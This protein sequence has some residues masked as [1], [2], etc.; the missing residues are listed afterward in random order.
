MQPRCILPL[1]CSM[2]YKLLIAYDGTPFGGWQYQDN[3]PSI[4]AHIEHALSTALRTPISIIG[5]GRT[6]SGVHAL[7]QVAHFSTDAPVSPQRLL[8]SLNALL[9]PDIRIL[10]IETAPEDFHAIY[11]AKAKLYTYHLHLDKQENPFKRH[12]SYRPL[13]PL[14]LTLLKEAAAHFVGTHDFTSFANQ[15]DEGSAAKNPIRTIHRLDVIDE[16]GGV[17]L[18]FQGTGFLYKMVRNITGTLLE[19]STG[20]IPLQSLPEIFAAKDRRKAG[21]TAPAHG[22]FLTEVFY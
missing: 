8:L 17:R 19:I 20:K 9:P 7:G 21:Q 22:L 5:S 11:S 12:H 2:K 1:S 18:E 6:D 14:N 4:Q 15:S 13:K 10:Q 16:A 3:A